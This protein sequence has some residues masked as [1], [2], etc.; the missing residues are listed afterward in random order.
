MKNLPA[1]RTPN[2][3]TNVLSLF[4]SLTF[5]I[6][7]L[8]FIRSLFDGTSYVWGT[9]YF[10]LNINGAGVTPSFIFLILQMSLYAAVIF[11]LYRMKNR[12][13]YGGLLGLWWLNVFGNLL[14]DIFKNGDTMFH[15]DTLN[16]HVSISTIVLPLSAV[17]LLLIIMVLRIEKEELLIPWTQKNRTLL[18]LFLGMLPILFLLLST[19]TPS[20]TSDQIGVILAI[21]QCFYIPF[22]FRPYKTQVQLKTNSI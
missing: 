5:M 6:V 18:Y 2:I 10:G 15:G 11:G 13:L 1:F 14:F 20:G 22:I 12:K 3:W 7:W 9:N 4:I 8:P 17:A 19:G 16:V 21:T